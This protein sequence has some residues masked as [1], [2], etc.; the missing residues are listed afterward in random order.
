VRAG[1][2]IARLGGDEFVVSLPA[3]ADDHDVMAVAG[4]ILQ[5]IREPYVLNQHELHISG[6]IGISLY[7]TDG[8]DAGALLRAADTAMYHAK[9][10][11]RDNYQYFTARLNDAARDRLLIANRLHNALERHEF[12]LH[13]QPQVDLESGRIVA[14]E[15]LIRWQPPE[16]GVIA[17]NQFIKVAEQSGLIVP[18]GAWVLREA[19]QQLKRLR[20]A[21]YPEL[22]MAV[23]VSPQQFRRPGFVELVADILNQAGLPAAALELELTEGVLTPESTENLAILV[24]LAKMGVQ[25]AVDD[26]G[27][28]YSSLAYLQH[29]PVHALKID[30][31]FTNGVGENPHDAALVTAIIA[32]AR[33]LRLRILAEGVET[34]DQ[35]TFLKEQGCNG[36]QGFYFGRPVSVEPFAALLRSQSRFS[37]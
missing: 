31:S 15:A 29:F 2:S 17:P 3:L 19:C 25:L 32:M 6:S 26:F 37:S 33:T 1:D 14:A 5:S 36:A 8:E 11:G 7:P 10:R 24:R 12:T 27:T 22:R 21:G 18:V 35:A 28:G 16:S 9:S 20:A 4:K 30:Q 34:V 23:N 13:Y